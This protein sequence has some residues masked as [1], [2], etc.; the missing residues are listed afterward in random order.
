MPL[1]S[2][3]FLQ[4]VLPP[5]PAALAAPMETGLCCTGIDTMAGFYISAF[6][7]EKISDIAVPGAVP[8][9]QFF[10]NSGYRVVR[11]QTPFG[12][13]LKLLAANSAATSTDTG[14]P[15]PSSNILE[16]KNTAFL[17]FIVSDIA[18]SLQRAIEL[19]AMAMGSIAEIRPGLSIVLVRD[20]EG[21]CLELAQYNDI[22]LY[23]PDLFP[24]RPPT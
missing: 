16:K 1:S 12:E 23:R 10:S 2:P 9:A 18:A 20:P 11:L 24:E 6:L 19:G 15:L 7:F 22:G 14:A 13:R 21:N 4:P 8:G 3:E 17:T 5:L